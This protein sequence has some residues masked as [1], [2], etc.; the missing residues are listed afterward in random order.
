MIR[1]IQICFRYIV[2]SNSHKELVGIIV[3]GNIFCNKYWIRYCQRLWSH[4]TY[5][6]YTNS[7]II[8]IS[9]SIVLCA[10][11]VAQCSWW[12]VTVQISSA[13]WTYKLV[14]RWTKLLQLVLSSVFVSVGTC[15]LDMYLQ[16]KLGT[17]TCTCT[18]GLS[19]CT[20]TRTWGL[21]T[22]TC[23]C[24]WGSVYLIHH[25]CVILKLCSITYVPYRTTFWRRH[26]T[27]QLIQYGYMH[28]KKLIGRRTGWTTTANSRR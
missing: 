10:E 12:H 6:R 1:G 18:W 19:T 26:W 7:I 11:T 21:G 13:V 3:V 5:L 24:T 8:I 4:S 20:C 9:I 16:C 22:C 14:K 17:C 2:K 27:R 28:G 25:W 23:T 15:V